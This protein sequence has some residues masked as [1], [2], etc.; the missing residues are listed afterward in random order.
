MKTMTGIITSLKNTN[1]ATV[2]VTNK[3]Q[4]PLYKK[5]V[6]RTKKYACHY[7]NMQLTLGQHVSIEECP[8]I[9]KTKH[10]RISEKVET[11]S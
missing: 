9:S 6:K 3:W 10:F 4:H 8:P 2:T 5:F 11:K 7:E 1:T